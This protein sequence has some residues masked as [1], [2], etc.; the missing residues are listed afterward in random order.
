MCVILRKSHSVTHT[1]FKIH[2]H[3]VLWQRQALTEIQTAF[4]VLQ[5]PA[6]TTNYT[7]LLTKNTA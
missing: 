5:P 4:S 1:S 6:T 3:E 2:I 7:Y